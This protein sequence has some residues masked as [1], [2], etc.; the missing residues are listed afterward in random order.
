MNK[1]QRARVFIILGLL[2][3]FMTGCSGT[4]LYI[5]W[6]NVNKVEERRQTTETHVI[7]DL[8]DWWNGKQS[9]K[10]AED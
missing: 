4:R 1:K 3:G 5:G 6:E 8:S 2:S 10:Q 7:R 9:T